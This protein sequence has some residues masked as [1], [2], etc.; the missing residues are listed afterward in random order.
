M[1]WIIIDAPR[2]YSSHHPKK[3]IL[4]C[5]KIVDIAKRRIRWAIIETLE[6]AAQDI[7]KRNDK[8]IS[9]SPSK[10]ID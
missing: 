6:P 5:L 3:R 2:T 8:T 9:K 1:N 7:T 10:T 4:Q